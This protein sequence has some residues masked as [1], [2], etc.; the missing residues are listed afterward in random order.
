M[1][2]WWNYLTTINQIFYIGAAFFS[3][4]FLGQLIAA[5]T[6]MDGDQADISDGELG[7]DIGSGDA[8]ED[9]A[10]IDSIETTVAF[11]L[12]SIRA[13]IIFFT[14]FFWGG[15]LYLNRGDSLRAAIGYSLIWG[16]VGMVCVSL[17]FYAMRRLTENGT[18]R[19]STCVG[20]EGS[21]YINIPKDGIGEIK[22]MVSGVVTHVNARSVSGKAINANNSVKVVKLTGSNTVEVETIN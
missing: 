12:L 13:L 6:G 21:V 15:S 1:S 20:K 3:V 17:V 10:Q 14:L 11:Q 4:I 18:A 22:V 2:Q 7:Q 8:F 19:L 9:G 16:V 5:F